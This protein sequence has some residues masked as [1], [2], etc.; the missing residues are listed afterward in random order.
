MKR[1]LPFFAKRFLTVSSLSLA[2]M[3]SAQI[4]NIPDPN[5]KE[6]LLNS[7]S[8]DSNG[9]SEIQVSEAAAYD[10]ALYLF[11][12]SGKTI[13][14]LTGLEAFTKLAVLYL[15]NVN[16]T[17]PV[18]D[19]G[20]HPNLKYL[21]LNAVNVSG[22]DTSNNPVLK[23]VWIRYSA[24][25]SA[26]FQQNTALTEVRMEYN[27][28]LTSVNIG[29]LDLNKVQTLLF[30]N[31]VMLSCVQVNDVA[32]ANQKFS[33]WKDFY[34]KY[35]LDCSTMQPPV[36][37]FVEFVDPVMKLMM[38]KNQS[39]NTNG[40]TEI[41]ISEAENYTLDLAIKEYDSNTQLSVTQHDF[42]WLKH[43]KNITGLSLAYDSVESIDLSFFNKVEN[44]Q[45][46]S[47]ARTKL[48]NVVLPT[49]SVIKELSI[50][51]TNIK[52]LD[53]SSQNEL[54][55][56]RFVEVPLTSLDLTSNTKLNEININCEKI[57]SIELGN[58]PELTNFQFASEKLQSLDF[59]H[60]P[61]LSNIYVSSPILN[62]FVLG[63]S[64]NLI[65]IDIGRNE[66]TVLDL[67]KAKNLQYLYIDENQLVNLDLSK[68]V[69]LKAIEIGKSN[70]NHLDLSN[71][72]LLTRVY[73]SANTWT[74]A[75]NNNIEYF[76]LI[77]SSVENF[78]FTGL[79]NAQNISVYNS[80]KDHIRLVA[81]PNNSAEIIFS[82]IRSKSLDLRGLSLDVL[83]NFSVYN[84]PN[85]SCI[86]VDDVQ[87]AQGKD[88]NLD[89]WNTITTDC[90]TIPNPGAVVPIFDTEVKLNMLY[91]N[92]LNKNF[93]NE[94][95]VT[96]AKDYKDLNLSGISNFTEANWLSYFENMIS[97]SISNTELPKINIEHNQAL[98]YFSFYSNY[99]IE[100]LDFS[101]NT[102]LK[103]IS[104]YSNNKLNSVNLSNITNQTRVVFTDSRELKCIQVDNVQ[105]ALQNV[106]NQ[107]WYV[108][109]TS[110][111]STNCFSTLQ[112]GDTKKESITLYPNPVDSIL[113]LTKPG[114]IKI[115]NSV[116]QLVKDAKG[117]AVD[118]SA[119]SKG[120][121]FIMILDN[122]GKVI[123]K[124]K[125]IKN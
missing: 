108:D 101:K 123:Q 45:I 82:D 15:S 60:T 51:N 83:D 102:G 35:S 107:Q 29:T 47:S 59:T 33:Q 124:S 95:Q 8:I 105:D 42:E 71:N 106:T 80:L 26:D 3:L 18:L 90:N 62:S 66:L 72:P 112:V 27:P 43:F 81:V 125:I 64:E 94:I 93:D 75:P 30:Q 96:E 100:T 88:W 98:E 117:D 46:S 97:L 76:G 104:S 77:S 14:D 84:N 4:V 113:Y 44:L 92:D 48:N 39:L 10:G 67:S 118:V 19:F 85:L 24:L 89:P 22:I 115:F 54:Q 31:N 40:D 37:P 79:D 110:L 111:F 5:L 116:G 57:S 25:T 2:G 121:Y 23:D 58:K 70:I 53:L 119:L 52:Q 99:Y 91:K 7:H 120:I 9:D 28:K 87:A 13:T 12:S 17:Q 41:Q 20:N 50:Q 109:D 86:L 114:V 34:T 21:N 68:L 65:S 32:K 74:I 11:A 56:I 1:V 63:T 6:L 73:H 36:G 55:M 16:L 69:D 38:I 122:N 103:E 78:D 61:N 49:Q